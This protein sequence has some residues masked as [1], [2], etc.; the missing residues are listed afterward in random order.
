MQSC[1]PHPLPENRLLFCP[2]KEGHI[3]INLG[4]PVTPPVMGAFSRSGDQES[5]IY[6]LTSEPKEHKSIFLPGCPAGS[7]ATGV[8]GQRFLC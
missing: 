5:E 1:C 2:G 6:A 4:R 3:N 7:P 8:R